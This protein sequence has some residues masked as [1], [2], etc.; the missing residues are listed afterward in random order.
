MWIP[1]RRA[2]T[3]RLRIMAYRLFRSMVQKMVN[4]S[5]EVIVPQLLGP[6][7]CLLF[8]FWFTPT[9]VTVIR[10]PHERVPS[11]YSSMA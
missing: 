6:K 7:P 4:I 5:Q 3:G 11:H 9:S 10:P 1:A 2:M 8:V